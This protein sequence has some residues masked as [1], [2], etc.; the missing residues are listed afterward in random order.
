[1][2]PIAPGPPPLPPLPKGGKWRAGIGIVARSIEGSLL[3]KPPLQIPLDEHFFASLRLGQADRAAVVEHAEPLG[4]LALRR[5]GVGETEWAE[6]V[7]SPAER[8]GRGA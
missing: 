5:L 3:I 7:E 4:D 2:S 6:V 8:G 1:M